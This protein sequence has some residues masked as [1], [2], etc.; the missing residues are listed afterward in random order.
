MG[1]A[2]EGPPDKSVRSSR[3]SKRGR[4]ERGR[5]RTLAGRGEMRDEQ[6]F[7]KLDAE[8]NHMDFSFEKVVCSLM[9]SATL[10]G[11]QTERRGGAGPVRGL[12]GGKASP[13]ASW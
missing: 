13:A 4:K 2:K 9:T 6:D 7:T 11:A 12:L 1:S 10:P 8:W 5:W 3:I